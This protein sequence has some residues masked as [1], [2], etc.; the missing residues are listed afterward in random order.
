M[1]KTGKEENSIKQKT[2]SSMARKHECN[3][4]K[5]V[6]RYNISDTISLTNDDQDGGDSAAVH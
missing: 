4:I 3:L 6:K 1:Q 5:Y 2:H